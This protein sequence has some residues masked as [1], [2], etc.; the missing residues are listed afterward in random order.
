MRR[1]TFWLAIALLLAAAAPRVARACP[2]C[3]DAATAS[4]GA[5]EEDATRE[6]R[7]YNNSI[8]LMAGMP[9][10]MLGGVGF[11]VYRGIRRHNALTPPP[12]EAVPTADQPAPNPD[13]T[14]P[15]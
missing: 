9:Y 11:W 3:A 14:N 15:G 12:A 5:D 6:A 8:Y 2:L 13:G 10:L 4:S 7:A 1:Y